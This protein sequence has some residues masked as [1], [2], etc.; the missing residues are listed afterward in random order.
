MLYMETKWKLNVNLLKN[1]FEVARRPK[2]SSLKA[3]NI[4]PST[5]N[6]WIAA[7]AGNRMRTPRK[8]AVFPSVR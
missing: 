3:A 1:I 4:K 7:E 8:R 5:W 2:L 6:G